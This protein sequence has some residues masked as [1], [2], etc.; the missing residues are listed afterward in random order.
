M[1]HSNIPGGA[2]KYV[3]REMGIHFRMKSVNNFF[4]LLVF[5][6][7]E[8]NG[9]CM[10]VHIYAYEVS[11]ENANEIFTVT[12]FAIVCYCR[13]LYVGFPKNHREQPNKK[14]NRYAM[15]SCWHVV[16]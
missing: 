10:K 2:I 6:G 3:E 12:A 7:Y 4:L 16:E 1:R 15:Q 5:L 11:E 8:T 13:L 14:D 9:G